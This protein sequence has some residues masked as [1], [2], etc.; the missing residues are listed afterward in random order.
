[1]SK[2]ENPFQDELILEAPTWL[3]TDQLEYDSDNSRYG[4]FQSTDQDEIQQHLYY[5]EDGRVLEKELIHDRRIFQPLYVQET[6][7]KTKD[8]RLIYCVRDGNRRTCAS[9]VL[10]NN[11]KSGKVKGFDLEH[12]AKVPVVV[13]K[14]T[15]QQIHV[16]L[17]KIHVAGAKPWQAASRAGHIFALIEQYSETVESVAEALGMPKSKVENAYFAYK[18][19][20]Q[21]GKVSS[22]KNTIKYFAIFDEFYRQ[23]VLRDWE[24]KDTSNMESFMQYVEE[25]KITD[26]SGVRKFAKII[27]AENPQRA[28]AISALKS[29]NGDVIKVFE[30]LQ[31]NT[32]SA[33]WE[34]V[35]QSLKMLKDFPHRALEDAAVDTEKLR[36]LNELILVATDLQKTIQE[37]QQRGL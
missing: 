36:T 21:F 1:M 25:K 7:R 15:D 19:T 24:K 6:N 17:G 11:I 12:F 37:I 31:N 14:G 4:D 8:G 23:K 26:G 18:K 22:D 10:T 3:S 27:A 13:L 16:F 2:T 20:Q 9:R 32:G 35:F 5:E 28:Q 34:K 30:T 29:L 33:S